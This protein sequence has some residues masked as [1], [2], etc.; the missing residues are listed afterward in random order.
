MNSDINN[1]EG[2]SKKSKLI[3]ILL[4]C[5]LIFAA[6]FLSAYFYIIPNSNYNKAISYIDDGEYEKAIVLL[7]ELGGFKDAQSLIEQTKNKAKEDK[8]TGELKSFS[9]GEDEANSA[10]DCNFILAYSRGLSAF[11]RKEYSRAREIFSSL[12]TY[13]ES[14]SYAILCGYRISYDEAVDKMWQGDYASAWELLD[15]IEQDSKISGVDFGLVIN[16]DEFIQNKDDA[17]NNMCYANGLENFEN[18]NYFYAYTWFNKANGILDADELASQCI[19]TLKTEELYFDPLFMHT[20]IE[21][22]IKV[23]KEYPM[24]V[25]IKIMAKDTVVTVVTIK[26]GQMKTLNLPSGYYTFMKGEGEKWFGEK[27]YFGTDG[28]YF[29]FLFDEDIRGDVDEEFEVHLKS[30]LLHEL[31]I[32]LADGNVKAVSI[33]YDEFKGK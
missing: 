3:V 32:G 10:E 21:L 33:S 2:K 9:D 15:S 4:L 26:S 30:G 13:K 31:E 28:D 17:Y 19:K 5:V 12:G 25:C 8:E 29:K 27:D 6:V 23:N 18:E 16:G 1:A 24:D 22:D 20:T 7:E 14:E 11:E